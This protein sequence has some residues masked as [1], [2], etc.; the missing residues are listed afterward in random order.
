[1]QLTETSQKKSIAVLQSVLVICVFLICYKA[2]A[3]ATDSVS[4]TPVKPVLRSTN[5]CIN[6]ELS[7]EAVSPK[8]ERIDWKY[9]KQ[10]VHTSVTPALVKTVA[11]IGEGTGADELR[12]P[13]GIAV[14][15]SGNIYIA[16]Q[17]N[18]RVQQW[19][20]GAVAGKTVAG[21]G[22]QGD[23]A[24]Q[25]NYPMAVTV[26]AAGNLYVSDAANSR[27]QM[28]TPGSYN[29][30]TVAG[31]NGRGSGA[32]QFNMPFGIC[33][34]QNGN[35]Y[36]AD[37]YNHRIQKWAPGAIEGIT[38]AGGNGKGNAANQ[39]QYPSSIKVDKS[40][41]LFIA[42]AAND[43]IQAWK[44]GGKTGITVAGGNGRGKGMAQLYFPTDI[45]LNAAGDIFISDQ[46]NQRIQCWKSGAKTGITV[47]G[48]N[49]QG[50]GMNQFNYPYGLTIDEDENMYV[51][52][53]Y[54][55]RI[56]F[57]QNPDAS[58]S[59]QFQFKA[60]RPGS[61]EADIIYRNGVIE[62]SA[63]LE[64]HDLPAI[65]PI[66][67]DENICS[68]KQYQLLTDAKDVKWKSSNTA[69]AEISTDGT[70]VGK[71]NGVVVVSYEMQ[72]MFGC[73]N[74]ASKTITIKETPSVPAIMP[75]PELMQQSGNTLF[76]S[77]LLCAGTSVPLN[78]ML[79]T[80]QW[81]S[82]DTN[83]AKIENGT[84]KGIS[85]GNVAISFLVEKN[86]CTAESRTEFV[87]LPVASSPIIQG[88]NKII[89]GQVRQLNAGTGAGTWSSL[90]EEVATIDQ[91]GFVKGIRPGTSMVSFETTNEQGCRVK[92][93]IPVTVQP[94]SPMVQDASYENRQQP[95]YIRFD[96]QV[97]AKAG[98]KLAF[99]Q[100]ASPNSLP[101]EPLVKNLPGTYR[102]WV[103]AME[104]GVASQRVAFSVT[105]TET[106][107]IQ[108]L[109]PVVMGN[110]AIHFFTIQL[111]SRKV[112]MPITIRIADMQGR[113]IELRQSVQANS[114]IQFGQ[115]YPSGQ[116]VAE[117]EQGS[118]RKAVRLVKMGDDN[119][120]V[121]FSSTALNIK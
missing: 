110:P 115:N 18:H 59:Y 108:Q 114:T 22:G 70:L 49:G 55:H 48:A 78:A 10:T 54:N 19:A 75:A 1:M 41:T 85:A 36:V 5:L 93:E 73:I 84:L 95:A 32:N 71:Q 33:L 15:H 3:L 24:D 67:V 98:V 11:G 77:Q 45:A 7:I 103:A 39:L 97:T 116:Y 86:G 104:N 43:R 96:Q 29:G 105:I 17:F 87:V 111:K 56:Q 52:D 53:Q 74:S 9:N 44:P 76:K 30:I 28:F 92:A 40:G 42:D 65:T 120:T 25:L 34:D 89:S 58:I 37:N 46:T 82:S 69:I 35:L 79:T 109:E 2:N 106:G 113:V 26:D 81:S 60:T 118:E 51:A 121:K 90:V 8:V 72:D 4:A 117:I 94:E 119:R 101:I 47:A 50:N 91:R 31:G 12:F 99:F 23:A 100:N 80:G 102:F 20:P 38:V 6:T 16:D 61:Y 57:F 21:M 13:S 88:Y 62:T 14:D 66:R 107:T 63:V 27:I 68:G 64:V 112:N 83:I